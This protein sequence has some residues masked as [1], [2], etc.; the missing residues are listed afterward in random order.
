MDSNDKKSLTNIGEFD[1]VVGGG[2]AKGSLTLLSG[3]PGIGKSTLTLQ[4]AN[5]LAKTEKT[6][7]ISGEE[8]ISQ[9]SQ[10]AFRLGLKE[11]NLTAINE[12]NLE[13]ILETIKQ[14]KSSVVIIDSIQVISSMDLP[15][16]A[17]SVTQVRYCTEQIMEYAKSTS[18]IVILIGHVTKDGNLAGPR[19]LEHLVDTVIHL[20]GDRF[21][22]FRIL[23][24]IKNRFGSCS[25]VGI[26]EMSEK[27][28]VEVKN[29]S[30]QFL[31]GRKENAIGSV[32]TVAMEGTRP[33]LVEVQALVSTSPFGYPK[34]TANGFDLNRL[35][36]LIAVLE[37]YG[38]V[39]LQNQ[40]VFINIV[41]GIKLTE[42][43]ADLAVLTAIA[44]SLLKKSIPSTTTIYGEVGLSGEL[45]RVSHSEKREKESKKLGFTK[46]LS[47]ENHKEIYTVLKSISD[48][49]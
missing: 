37:K 2:L 41:G 4:V 7:L 36:I 38:K 23:R 15:S 44:S 32:I 45:R 5:Q 48:S 28:M 9:I 8:S 24:A 25:E 26:F 17:G 13:T 14:E 43:A 1:R 12:Y 40:D 46:I 22:Q 18:T 47:S 19:V 33:F 21:Q 3:E 49:A 39:N 27:G 16:A 34:R 20:E 42:P 10:R 6:L 31:E 30:E 35:Q 11:K 29:P